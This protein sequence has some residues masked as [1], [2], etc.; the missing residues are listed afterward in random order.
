VFKGETELHATEASQ[1]GRRMRLGDFLGGNE[2]VLSTNVPEPELRT[3]VERMVES[4]LQH[5]PAFYER[6]R[7]QIRKMDA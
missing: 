2:M 6:W 1:K 5:F 4:L 3:N 7:Y